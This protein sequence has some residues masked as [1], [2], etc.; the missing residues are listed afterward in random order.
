MLSGGETPRVRRRA[1]DVA[2]AEREPAPGGRRT[3]HREWAVHV[4]VRAGRVGRHSA[5][6]VTGGGGE[7]RRRDGDHRCPSDHEAPA[8]RACL[9][10]VAPGQHEAVDIAR[11]HAQRRRA[12]VAEAARAGSA[13]VGRA[14][15]DQN[16]DLVKAPVPVQTS[17]QARPHLGTSVVAGPA[18]R[19]GDRARRVGGGVEPPDTGL[20]LLVLDV[21]AEGGRRGL[22]VGDQVC[23]GARRLPPHGFR[24][25]GGSHGQAGD[26]E[27][28][29]HQCDGDTA[30]GRQP[31]SR[32]AHGTPRS[33][34]LPGCAPAKK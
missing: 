23:I 11:K 4:V 3:A 26:D 30:H 12:L 24:P 25:V 10:G 33:V 18:P 1:G 13:A 8:E 20:L 5:L 14:G 16:R 2:V 31:G 32:W 34:S 27:E 6:R 28:C 29:P 9:L 7:G 21:V 19:E 17:D 15:V 22:A